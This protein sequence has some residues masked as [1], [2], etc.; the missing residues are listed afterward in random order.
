[1]VH[2]VNVDFHLCVNNKIGGKGCHHQNIDAYVEEPEV[3]Q[4]SK[5][6]CRS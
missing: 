2:F 5:S 4:P 6:R 1:M 3:H